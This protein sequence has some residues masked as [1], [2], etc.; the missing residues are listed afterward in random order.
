MAE[1]PLICGE[2]WCM[3]DPN[4]PQRPQNPP[5]LAALAY[6]VSD[7]RQAKQRALESLYTVIPPGSSTLVALRTRDAD[8]ATIALIDA[9]AMVID[10]LTFYQ[11]RI[12]NEGY[13]RTAIERRSLLEL[14]RTIGCELA[15]G[16]AASTYLVFTVES[17]PTAPK[18]VTVS[19]G[20]QIAS[21]PGENEQSQTFETR[22]PLI[23]RV[24]WNALKPRLTRPQTLTPQTQHLYLQGINTQLQVGDRVLLIDQPMPEETL[25][26]NWYLLKLTAVELLTAIGQTRIAWE[27]QL[28]STVVP[29]HPRLFAFRQ[30]VALFGNLAPKWETLPAEVKQRYSPIRGGSFRFSGGAWRSVN[31]GLPTFDRRC[32]AA[33][34][35]QFLFAGTLG[36]GIFRSLDRGASWQQMTIGLSNLAIETLYCSDQGQVFAGSPAGGVFRS[37][38]NGETWTAIGTGTVR[39]QSTGENSWEAVNTALPNTV[40]RCLLAYTVQAPSGSGTVTSDENHYFLFVGTDDGVYR[41]AD[42]GQN[43]YSKGLVARSIR[44]FLRHDPY[45]YAASDRGVYRCSTEHGDQ[46]ELSSQ[47]FT[48]PTTCLAALTLNPGQPNQQNY[49]FAGTISN[50]VYRSTN[51]G[52]TWIRTWSP[53]PLDITALAVHNT[54]LYAGTGSGKVFVSHDAGENWQDLSQETI[55]AAITALAVLQNDLF[56]GAK[57]GGFVNSDWSDRGNLSTAKLRLIPLLIPLPQSLPQSLPQPPSPSISMPSIRRFCPRVG[58]CC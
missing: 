38:D 20:T 8:D 56:V 6:R 17:T 45:L 13:W 23:A 19:Q 36:G 50:G 48:E 31:A 43:W 53:L 16:V 30:Q 39:V 40:V 18:Q 57:F 14:A 42:Q 25:E 3:S 21:V 12:A 24:D 46:W 28:A 1:L 22:E 26:T 9:W 37:R 41:S 7:Y 5:G 55:G 10:V 27:T 2:D 34:S 15:P 33:K 51:A 29:R 32:L 35:P 49:L 54:T 52:T 58:S 11:E 44:A 47:D 4:L